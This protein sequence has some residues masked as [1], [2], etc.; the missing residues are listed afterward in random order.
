MAP[1]P[2]SLL[3]TLIGWQV[4]GFPGAVAAT[5]GIFGPTAILVYGVAVVWKRHEGALWR[6]ALEGGLRPV[7]AGMIRASVYVLLLS[8]DG[9][10]PAQAIAFASTAALMAS[11]ANPL[12]LLV[13]GAGVFLALHGNG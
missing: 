13:V 10:W 9:G 4:A 6:R 5:L 11:R 2:G 3:A 12:A 1:G 7:A 8:L